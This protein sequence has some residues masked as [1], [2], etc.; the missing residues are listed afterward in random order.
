M[1]LWWEDHTTSTSDF[2]HL[3]TYGTFCGRVVVTHIFWANYHVVDFFVRRQ[4]RILS[5]W[6]LKLRYG[7]C[8]NPSLLNKNLLHRH[9]QAMAEFIQKGP[10]LILDH[11]IG[12]PLSFFSPFLFFLQYT[13][14]CQLGFRKKQLVFYGLNVYHNF[15]CKRGAHLRKWMVCPILITNFPTNYGRQYFELLNLKVA[16]Q[17]LS[18]QCTR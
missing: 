15:I 11:L 18:L 8:T 1:T 12:S 3:V 16:Y 10:I 13:S 2:P 9:R 17:C 6:D 5:N 7:T 4:N 14:L